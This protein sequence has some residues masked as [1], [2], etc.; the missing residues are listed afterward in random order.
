MKTL[1]TSIMRRGIKST[2]ISWFQ[3]VDNMEECCS[4]EGRSKCSNLSITW[5]ES[6]EPIVC[7]A[8]SWNYSSFAAVFKTSFSKYS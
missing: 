1:K 8:Y 4:L 5:D 6:S 3:V 7:N 2:L